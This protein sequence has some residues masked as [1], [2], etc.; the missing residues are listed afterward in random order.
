MDVG[1]LTLR[2][3]RELQS[4]G[5]G[6][7][8]VHIGWS[9][10]ILPGRWNFVGDFTRRGDRLITE[11][12]RVIAYWGTGE[13]EGL[14]HLAEKGPTSKTILLAPASYDLPYGS[15]AIMGASEDAWS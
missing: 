15:C 6:K 10:V 1:D 5:V 7:S 2:Q 12:G 11:S 14:G 13:G 3:I 4:I 8:D 9:I